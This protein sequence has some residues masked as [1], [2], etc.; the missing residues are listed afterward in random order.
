[1]SINIAQQK[2]P[3]PAIDV[4]FRTIQQASMFACTVLMEDA[5]AIETIVDYTS[6]GNTILS[7]SIFGE[8]ERLLSEMSLRRRCPDSQ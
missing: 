1:V 5:L 7:F 4:A 3:S 6:T 2:N 8:S